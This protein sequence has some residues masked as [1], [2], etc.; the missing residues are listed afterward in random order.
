MRGRG[1]RSCS[2][3]GPRREP[4]PVAW[5]GLDRDDDWSP[6]FWLGV[7][8]ALVSAGALGG[9][10]DD[11]GDGLGTR[12][13]ER[14]DGRMEPVV[15]VLDDFHEIEGPIVQRELQT[16]LDHAPSGLRLVLVDARR[17]SAAPPAPPPDRRNLTEIR[18]TQL[19]FT[20]DECG[21]AL[22]APFAADL[23]HTDVEALREQT[24]G[25]AAGI[26]LATLSLASEPD[27]DRLPAPLRRRR[28]G[29]GGLLAER[30]PRPA[31]RP[32]ARVPAPHVRPGH[33]QCR[34]SRTR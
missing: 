1:K 21:E 22:K 3:P 30:D 26:R 4:R 13:A 17:S 7:E 27:R 28:P 16:L 19:A 33:D 15:L 5:L 9:P 29:R 11:G 6:R 14:L 2:R 23:A 12:I 24:E 20:V 32:P 8:R 18:A 25:W 10:C 34:A 31:A